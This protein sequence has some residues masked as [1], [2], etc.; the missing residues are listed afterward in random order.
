MKTKVKF[1]Q[2][3]NKLSYIK[4]FYHNA[5]PSI[6]LIYQILRSSILWKNYLPLHFLFR[7]KESI[8][9]IMGT[10][11]CEKFDGAMLEI[12]SG[13]KIPLI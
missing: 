7:E 13:P 2:E 10:A 3:T 1:Q 12:Y 11:K 6:I 4:A 9:M 8:I 5:L